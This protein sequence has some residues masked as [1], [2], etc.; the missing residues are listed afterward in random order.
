MIEFVIRRERLFE[1][2]RDRMFPVHPPYGERVA[3]AVSDLAT[4]FHALSVRGQLAGYLAA[5]RFYEIGSLA[6][7]KDFEQWLRRDR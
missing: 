6:G 2:F 4:L 1:T 7:L 3:A 5:V